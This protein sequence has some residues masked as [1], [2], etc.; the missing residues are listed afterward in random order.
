MCL[1][2]DKTSC[3]ALFCSRVNTYL[4]SCVIFEIISNIAQFSKRIIMKRSDILAILFVGGIL[5]IFI[6]PESRE[7]YNRAY[8]NYAILMSFMKFALL[9]TFGEMLVLRL[10]KGH[11]NY[12]EFGL[13]PKALVWGFLGITLY[14]AFAIFAGGVTNMIQAETTPM[15]VLQ[16]FSISFFMNI[17]Y[18]PILMLSHHISDLFIADNNGRFPVGKWRTKV[19]L[20]KIDWEKMWGFVIKKTIPL[21]WIP[22]HTITFLLPEQYRILLAAVLSIVLGLFLATTKRSA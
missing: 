21:F 4:I 22:V 3:N 6:F 13:L 1:K 15:R 2:R 20:Q 18:A 8:E 17:F 16:S 9:A 19:L 10:F 7:W 12:K 5:S 14:F 11:Y